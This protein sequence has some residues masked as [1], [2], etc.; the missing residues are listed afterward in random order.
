MKI[1]F[2]DT[3]NTTAVQRMESLYLI[4]VELDDLHIPVVFDTGATMTVM[5]KT[6]IGFY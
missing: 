4:V 3:T 6:T 1:N 2:T 5:N